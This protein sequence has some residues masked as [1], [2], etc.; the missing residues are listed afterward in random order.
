LSLLIFYYVYRKFYGQ[1]VGFK[2]FLD[3]IH[4]SLARKVYLPDMEI[5]FNLRDWPLVSTE[6][7][8]HIPLF[9]SCGTNDT[10][11]LVMPTYGITEATLEC[12]GR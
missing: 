5:L 4:F 2:M 6:Q 3:A 7:K 8:P 12:M 1:Y 11:D 9:S 10:L